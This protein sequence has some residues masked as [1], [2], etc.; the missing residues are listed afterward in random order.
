MLAVKFLQPYAPYEPGHVVDL[1]DALAES[2]IAS[3]TC[4]AYKSPVLPAQVMA[5]QNESTVTGGTNA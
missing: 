2:L 5:T 3:D 4:R 1:P